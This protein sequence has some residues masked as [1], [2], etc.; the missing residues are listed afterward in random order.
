[1]DYRG[2][3]GI[4]IEATLNAIPNGNEDAIFEPPSYIAFKTFLTRKHLK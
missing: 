2:A 3:G 1:M 4:D